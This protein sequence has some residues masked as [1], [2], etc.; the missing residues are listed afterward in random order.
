MES[1]DLLDEN[2]DLLL[3]R[4]RE[5]QIRIA[6]LEEENKRQHEEV[7]Q[8]HAALLQYRQNYQHLESAYALLGGSLPDEDKQKVEQ[9]ITNLIAQVDRALKI[10]S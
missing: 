3:T 1:L 7:M 8:V 10:L 5:Q 9:R 4:Y 2:I 6:A